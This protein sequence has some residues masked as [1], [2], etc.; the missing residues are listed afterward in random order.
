MRRKHKLFTLFIVSVLLIGVSVYFSSCQFN[1]Q[2]DYLIEQEQA[3]EVSR[4]DKEKIV[5]IILENKSTTEELIFET[6]AGEINN[7]SSNSEIIQNEKP[8]TETIWVITNPYPVELNQSRIMKLVESFSTLTADKV[9]ED[10]P[11]NLSKYGLDTPLAIGTA[12]LKD[13]TRVTL[14]L[15]SKAAD[16]ASWYLMKEGDSK[17]YAVAN[18]YGQLLTSSLSD[19]RRKDLPVI[20]PDVVTYLKISA[21]NREE[22]EIINR[23]SLPEGQYSYGINSYYFTKPY[24]RIRGVEDSKIH[25]ILNNLNG[26][27]IEEF[28]DDQPTDYNKYGLDNPRLQLLVKDEDRI[29]L[30]LAFG[31]S[32]G[33]GTV[34][35]KSG[36]SDGVNLMD[37]SAIEF[38][39]F[40]PFEIA[41]KYAMFINMEDL[42]K[43]ILKAGAREHTLS[44]TRTTSESEANGQ[45]AES[46]FLD[47]KNVDEQPFKELYQSMAGITIDDKLLHR[48]K[49]IPELKISYYPTKGEY[50]AYTLEFYPYDRE[51]YSLVLDGEME[52]E[53]L[54]YRSQLNWILDSLDYLTVESSLG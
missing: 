28:I 52:S 19:F 27:I 35:F 10:Q 15:G 1:T 42:G 20:N 40:E 11:R 12:Y 2:T 43:I 37:E 39:N 8:D 53:F 13:G 14:H 48:A 26:L 31:N 6:Q 41:D 32:L 49:G 23:E 16:G 9:V 5:K 21:D 4:M 38:L 18:H 22:I 36:D 29:V 46:Y 54:V 30:D 50:N 3:I 24:K 17:V 51:F 25:E 7:Q 47:G 33:D 45:L 34:Y 44:I